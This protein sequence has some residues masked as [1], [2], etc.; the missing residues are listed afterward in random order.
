MPIET[1]EDHAQTGGF[2]TAV[3]ETLNDARLPADRLLRLGQPER[4][5]GPASRKTQLAETGLDADGIE[6]RTR[7]LLAELGI[8]PRPRLVRDAQGVEVHS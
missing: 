4:W 1:L 5:I 2:G 3:L 7:A 8:E 6:A